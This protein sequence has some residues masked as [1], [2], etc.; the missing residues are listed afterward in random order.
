[1]TQGPREHGEA[2]ASDAAARAQHYDEIYASPGSLPLWEARMHAKG[3]YGAFDRIR[4]RMVSAALRDF[5][6]AG[7]RL[8]DVGVVTPLSAAAGPAWQVVGIDIS[9]NAILSG[10]G[11]VKEAGA[12]A[13]R[14]EW[15]QADARSLPFGDSTFDALIAGEVIEHF[16]EGEVG[17][18]EW[19]R[20]LRPGGLLILT[21]PNARRFVNRR[22]ALFQAFKGAREQ[23][24]L[25][26]PLKHEDEGGLHT[27]EREYTKGELEELTRR[28]GFDLVRTQGLGFVPPLA[29]AAISLLVLLV[30]AV[31]DR[32]SLALMVAGRDFSSVANNLVVIAKGAAAP[33]VKGP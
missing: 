24:G 33:G 13:P 4:A 8:L 6:P 1:M 17:L 12:L 11:K 30:P 23:M 32:L 31:A 10:K 22:F 16:H 29:A 20:V 19:R 21:T 14:F 28:C 26:R 9:K 25:K 3:Q 15:S 27:H 2:L 7:G 18:R 5:R